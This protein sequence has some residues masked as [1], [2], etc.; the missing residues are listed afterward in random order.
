[1]SDDSQK[2]WK[3]LTR[4]SKH[5]SELKF[6]Q[7]SYEAKKP[8]TMP[9][10]KELL[11]PKVMHHIWDGDIP[12][13]YQHFFDEC[14]NLHPDWEFKI[15]SAKDI[16]ALDLRYQNLYDNMRNYPGQSD[17]ARYEILYR[18]GGVYKDLDVKCYRPIDELNY[19][20]TFYA[21]LEY[22]MKNW[23]R[24]VVNNG[25]IAASPN[26]E[27]LK[28]TLE[29]I[30]E[31]FD[32][33][34][35]QFDNGAVVPSISAMTMKVSMIPLTDAFVQTSTIGDKN[36][37]LP[38][39]Y[40]FP[41][42]YNKSLEVNSIA[43]L[44][45]HIVDSPKHMYFQF[46]KP[47]TLMWH[48]FNK[49]EV[50][51]AEFDGGNGLIDPSRKRL[52]DRLS[53]YSQQ[54]YNVFKEIY[55]SNNTDK[56][57]WS[58]K[59]KTPQVLHFVVF[60]A[61]EAVKLEK[62]LPAW[63]MFNGDFEI[64]VWDMEKITTEFPDICSLVGQE[65][66]D[67]LRFYFALKVLEKFG[68]NY[69]NFNSQPLSSIFELSNK[70]NFYAALT[71]VNKNT[72]KISLSQ[73]MLGASH[74][75]PIISKTLVKINRTNQADLAKIDDILITE[76]YKNIYFYD[77]ISGKN[78]VLPAIYFEPLDPLEDDFWYAPYDYIA[79]FFKN[80][81]KSFIEVY[82]YSILD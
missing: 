77:E 14:K 19:K 56:V 72:A 30:D 20:Y 79:R 21:P 60:N 37:A 41:L 4:D 39:S 55:K 29:I 36:I 16:A 54:T 10:A 24:V 5:S 8:S 34:W 66:S 74:H 2:A 18:F 46:I 51:F 43:K 42:A 44:I 52:F 49:K 23:G 7:D 63:K 69:A 11:I 17:I 3:I 61:E 75:H 1:M 31:N 70:Y 38:A 71:P 50:M 57:G 76:A 9:D 58:K 48:N 78:V 62:N 28:R 45:R 33:N 32:S 80:I 47:E 59:S 25:I 73:K 6:F 26:H 81:P 65:K 53:D 82:G 13:L 27:I 12:P 64:K 40:F 15:W 67:N 68:G 35:S 22:P